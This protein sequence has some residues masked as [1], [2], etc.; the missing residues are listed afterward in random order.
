MTP[1]RKVVVLVDVDNTLLDNDKAQ[2]DYLQ[3]IKENPGGHAS[4][5]GWMFSK[6]RQR[7]ID[8]SYESCT[9][10]NQESSGSRCR[11]HARQGASYGTPTR[12]QDSV[13]PKDDRK[14]NGGR[15]EGSHQRL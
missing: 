10:E 4:T 8:R 12:A 3:H 13:R 5:S 11:R 7:P 1:K 2:D 6:R 9:E 15:R 14:Q